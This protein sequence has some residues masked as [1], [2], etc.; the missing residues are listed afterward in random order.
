M[1]LLHYMQHRYTEEK[2]THNKYFSST[3]TLNETFTKCNN[4]N[5]NVEPMGKI[6]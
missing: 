1:R 2:Q 6:L 4:A 5:K 3:G